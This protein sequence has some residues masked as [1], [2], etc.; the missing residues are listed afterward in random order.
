MSDDPHD[1]WVRELYR[2]LRERPQKRPPSERERLMEQLGYDVAWHEGLVIPTL[3]LE[4]LRERVA[5]QSA[6]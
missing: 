1:P 4:E 2:L 5:Q 6:K 3:T